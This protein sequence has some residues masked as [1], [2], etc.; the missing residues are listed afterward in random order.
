MWGG[1]WVIL[2]VNSSTMT[3]YSK[4]WKIGSGG[5]TSDL[6]ARLPEFLFKLILVAKFYMKFLF[7]ISILL[8]SHLA[9]ANP[10]GEL[11]RANSNVAA[12]IVM[13]NSI[14]GGSVSHAGKVTAVGCVGCTKPISN[15]NCIE[16]INIASGVGATKSVVIGG[17]RNI[18][19][20]GNITAS[21]KCRK[22]VNVA[23]GRNANSEVSIG[24]NGD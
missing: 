7:F 22:V 11:A 18:T 16:V 23:H 10:A 19:S 12:T 13:T 20:Q 21:A 5:R 3:T 6:F 2:G 24:S 8:A 15:D 17:N 9:Y 1:G 14:V 4:R